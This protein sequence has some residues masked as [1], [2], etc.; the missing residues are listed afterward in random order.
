MYLW[1]FASVAFFFLSFCSTVNSN[2][3]CAGPEREKHLG[4]PKKK[5]IVDEER[6]ISILPLFTFS[7]GGF[8]VILEM[9]EDLPVVAKL[10]ALVAR[11]R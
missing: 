2:G 11:P 1:V 4:S 5:A 9:C 10:A 8:G 7:I 6:V 3:R